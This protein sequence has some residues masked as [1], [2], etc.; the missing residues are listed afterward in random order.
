M[1]TIA[2]TD[3]RHRS[4]API[5]VTVPEGHGQHRPALG[6]TASMLLLRGKMLTGGSMLLGHHRTPGVAFQTAK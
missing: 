5:S 1:A 6:S 4:E 3:D 2:Y